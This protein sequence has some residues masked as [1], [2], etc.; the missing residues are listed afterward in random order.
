[1]FGFDS[2]EKSR[3]GFIKHLGD[4][5][6]TAWNIAKQ[7]KLPAYL[8][9]QLDHNNVD[10]FIRLLEQF[11]N[12]EDVKMALDKMVELEHNSSRHDPEK[13]RTLWKLGGATTAALMPHLAMAQQEAKITQEDVQNLYDKDPRIILSAIPNIILFDSESTAHWKET[14]LREVYQDSDPIKKP[15]LALF[16]TSMAYTS[17]TDVNSSAAIVVKALARYFSSQLR[18]VAF[19]FTDKRLTDE[20]L[21]N[22]NAETYASEMGIFNTAEGKKTRTLPPIRGPPSFA[23][24][25]PRKSANSSM[26]HMELLDVLIGSPKQ[27]FVLKWIYQDDADRGSYINWIR[28]NVA[29]N[30]PILY[31]GKNAGPR[32]KPYQR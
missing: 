15:V 18:Y 6:Q 19:H 23:L 2:K 25:A 5:D 4:N 7:A 10:E 9:A 20:M 3:I 14:Y 12:E 30:S 31:L 32:A 27:P 22:A 29:E 28:A 21:A 11:Q 8:R 17:P 16:Y 24:Y 13:R 1:M 26:A